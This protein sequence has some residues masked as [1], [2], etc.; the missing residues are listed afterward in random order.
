MAK[1]KQNDSP[2]L[3]QLVMSG[4]GTENIQFVTAHRHF[5]HFTLVYYH[6]ALHCTSRATHLLPCD[7]FVLGR[8]P[9]ARVSS[10]AGRLD[11]YP[12]SDSATKK[13]AIPSKSADYGEAKIDGSHVDVC[14]QCTRLTIQ[15]KKIQFT[16]ISPFD[17]FSSLDQV[18]NTHIYKIPVRHRCSQTSHDYIRLKTINK[19]IF[20]RSGVHDCVCRC[21]KHTRRVG[22]RDRVR[23]FVICRLNSETIGGQSRSSIIHNKIPGSIT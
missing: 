5:T 2:V 7:F 16:S 21:Q 11:A 18:S 14:E 3:F 10:Y 8:L 17:V 9:P 23:S 15:T 22:T 1:Y 19:S 13:T 6:S 12:C 4:P 20:I